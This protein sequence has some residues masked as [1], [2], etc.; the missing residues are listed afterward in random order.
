MQKPGHADQRLIGER[1]AGVRMC[2]RVTA[3]VGQDLTVLGVG[4]EITRGP[5]KAGILQVSK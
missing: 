3:N 1:P 2:D 4:A 5:V